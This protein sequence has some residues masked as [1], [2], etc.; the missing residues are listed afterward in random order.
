ML[1]CCSE[2]VGKSYAIKDNQF[3]YNRIAEY[4]VCPI[5]KKLILKLTEHRYSDNKC[6]ISLYKGRKAHRILRELKPLFITHIKKT[7]KHGTKSNNNWVFGH[8]TITKNTKKVYSVNFNGE[9]QR[10]S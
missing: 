5:C 7:I 10:I 2:F 1:S 9:K 6:F 8:T 3:F 4:D